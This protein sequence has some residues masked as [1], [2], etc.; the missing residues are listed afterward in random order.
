[1]TTNICEIRK[2]SF[3]HLR[4]DIDSESYCGKTVRNGTMIPLSTWGWKDA[5]WCQECANLHDK[6][7]DGQKKTTVRK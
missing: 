5:K 1:M 6:K 2:S 3:F 7:I 4:E